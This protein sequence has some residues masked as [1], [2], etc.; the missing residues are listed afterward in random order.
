MASAVSGKVS[1]LSIAWMCFSP[2][3]NHVAHCLARRERSLEHCADAFVLELCMWLTDPRS[4]RT[5][6]DLDSSSAWPCCYISAALTSTF[7]FEAALINPCSM[8]GL[9]RARGSLNSHYL[10]TAEVPKT[11]EL[12]CPIC[13]RGG[14]DLI[15]WGELHTP[16]STLM[17]S[18]DTQQRAIRTG[19][20]LGQPILRACGNQLVI[21]RNCHAVYVL[22]KSQK[23]RECKAV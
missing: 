23:Y 4:W 13:W 7:F 20:Q 21:W 3:I 6:L 5:R 8:H 9:P 10:Q 19:P 22:E 12:Q 17:S 11:P 2:V 14:Q 18:E 16:D 1:F 15:H